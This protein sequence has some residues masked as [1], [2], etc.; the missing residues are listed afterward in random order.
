M[1]DRAD[2]I[3][4]LPSSKAV[5]LPGREQ[6]RIGKALQQITAKF[7]AQK[8]EFE[9]VNQNLRLALLLAVDCGPAYKSAP[10]PIKR[11]FNQAFFEKVFVMQF[12]EYPG[13]IRVMAQHRAPFDVLLSR[14]LK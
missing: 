3:F 9:T 14:D 5:D 6:E 4:R 2:P 10:D 1:G 8:T 11:L 7:D 13:E 12:D